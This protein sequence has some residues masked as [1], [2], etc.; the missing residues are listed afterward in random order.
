MEENELGMETFRSMQEK[1]N[2]PLPY[3][4]YKAPYLSLSFS[5]SIEAVRTIKGNELL[6]KLSTDELL[7]YAW[8][9]SQKEVSTKEYATH[10]AITQ[11]TASR[12]LANMYK[13]GVINTNGEN[14]KS[15]RLKY[16][17]L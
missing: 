6:Q 8:I 13:L 7:G 1:Y 10:F 11:R 4:D 14:L 16:L 9:K 3:Y 15:P 5:R 2:L 17:M 12:H